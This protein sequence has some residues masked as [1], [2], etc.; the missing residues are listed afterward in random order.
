[1]WATTN[2]DDPV[3]AEGEIQKVAFKS[4]EAGEGGNS[5]CMPGF[6]SE[7]Q[8]LLMAMDGRGVPTGLPCQPS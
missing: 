6:R 5:R 8:F 3:S 2:E 4:R 7:H 1:M